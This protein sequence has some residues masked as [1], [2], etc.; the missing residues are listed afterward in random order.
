M[1]TIQGVEVLIV[2]LD[3]EKWEVGPNDTERLESENVLKTS[4]V[5]FLLLGLWSPIIS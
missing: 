3:T 1:T 4:C 2:G 5:L